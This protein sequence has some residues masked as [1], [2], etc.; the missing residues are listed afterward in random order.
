M[1]SLGNPSWTEAISRPASHDFQLDGTLIKEE[2][3]HRPALVL[4]EEKCAPPTLTTVLAIT[5]VSALP[6]RC[7][8]AKS[9]LTPFT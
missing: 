9:K 4:E 8:T 7:N 1:H 6:A 5:R 3:T 2:I